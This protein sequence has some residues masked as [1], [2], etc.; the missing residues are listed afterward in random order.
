M[1]SLPIIDLRTFSSIS[2]LGTSLVRAGKNPGFFYVTGIEEL[3]D[4]AVSPVFDVAA[5]FFNETAPEEKKAWWNGSGDLVRLI[6]LFLP[7][8]LFGLYD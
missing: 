4:E 7:S 3:N 2:D 8:A 6:I 5:R 1:A